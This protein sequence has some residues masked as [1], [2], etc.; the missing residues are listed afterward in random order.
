MTLGL[1]IDIKKGEKARILLHQTGLLDSSKRLAKD[2]AL[3]VFPLTRMLTQAE[4]RSLKKV[5]GLFSFKKINFSERSRKPRSLEDALKGELSEKE[6]SELVKSFDVIGKIALLLVSD[7]LLPKQ[8]IIAEALLEANPQLDTVARILGGHEGEYRVRPV[9]VIAGKNELE[10]IHTEWGC[11]F[12]VKLG[13]VFFSPRLSHERTRIAKLIKEGEDQGV[14]F[15]G[16]GPFAVIF[17]KHSKAGKI[18]AVELNPIAAALAEENIKLNKLEGKVTAFEGD[19][20]EIVPKHLA[21]KCDRIVMPLP[22]GG[23]HFLETAFLALKPRGGIIHFYRF[24][25]RESLYE[26]PLALIEA[27]AKKFNRKVKIKNKKIVRT[28]SPSKVQ[29]VIDAEVK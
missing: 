20:K 9:E 16:V 11:K 4:E 19:V 2:R 3:I 27:T 1:A 22:H 5:L 13:E 8:K 7:E 18:Y 15:S 6:M 29:V 21:G 23:E 25:D 28:F 26:K 24:V 17:G 12:K 14:F 10:T